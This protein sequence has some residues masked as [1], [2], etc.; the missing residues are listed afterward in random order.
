MNRKESKRHKV[1]QGSILGS[2]L[3]VLYINYLP[4]LTKSYTFLV[5]DDIKIFRTITDKSYYMTY[6]S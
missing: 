4:E 5:A 1:T 6:I 3:F 2:L